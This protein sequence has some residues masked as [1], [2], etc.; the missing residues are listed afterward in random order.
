MNIPKG[1]TEALGT[2]ET[3]VL[4][5]GTYPLLC[6]ER[7][8]PLWEL[9]GFTFRAAFCFAD[10]LLERNGYRLVRGD[11]VKWTPLDP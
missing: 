2:G 8:K 5:D 7:L 10:N 4:T 6:N 1:F 3:I 9:R 11:K